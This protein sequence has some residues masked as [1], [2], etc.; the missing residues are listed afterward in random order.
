MS[1]DAEALVE[2]GRRARR[3]GRF[4]EALSFYEKAAAAY[5]RGDDSLKLAHTVRHVGDIHRQAGR[6]EVAEPLHR[7]A[8]ALYRRHPDP[9]RLDLAN[10]IRP[11]AILEERAGRVDEAR[12]LW[13]EA[14]DLYE[15]CGVADG[16][17]ESSCR[18]AAL[19][20]GAPAGPV[21]E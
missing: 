13:A 9:P 14:R 11:L 21:R 5:R 19:G 18:L 4:E 10:A 15:A 16:A 1:S 3:E 12:R 8:L 2:A 17:T 7:E 6:P 20:G